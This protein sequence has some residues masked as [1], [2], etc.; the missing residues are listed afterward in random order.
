MPPPFASPRR[1]CRDQLVPNALC[2]PKRRRRRINGK[3]LAQAVV[4]KGMN[5]S[6]PHRNIGRRPPS[7]QTHQADVQSAV[8]CHCFLGTAMLLYRDAIILGGVSGLL[9]Y[10]FSLS[11]GQLGGTAIDS[12]SVFRTHAV[13]AAAFCRARFPCPLTA[14]CGGKPTG[15]APSRPQ[16]IHQALPK[17]LPYGEG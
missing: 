16:S 8:S 10:G 9:P 17:S 2:R 12:F 13:I 5:G 11:H 7:A 3:G 15:T 6:R 4:R 1:Q 14:L